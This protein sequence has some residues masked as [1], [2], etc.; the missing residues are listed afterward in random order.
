MLELDWWFAKDFS[1][2]LKI[3][4][5]TW[6]LVDKLRARYEDNQRKKDEQDHQDT[7]P[8]EP[9]VDNLDKQEQSASE[10]T[11]EEVKTETDAKSAATDIDQLEQQVI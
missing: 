4:R 1:I 8:H 7:R 9:A 10:G 3:E 5:E 11:S 6:S 2:V